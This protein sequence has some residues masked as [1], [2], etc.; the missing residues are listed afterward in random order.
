MKPLD[1]NLE[2]SNAPSIA[3]PGFDSLTTFQLTLVNDGRVVSSPKRKNPK[4]GSDLIGNV[5][6]CP[7]LEILRP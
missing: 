4:Y 5:L 3:R 7:D 1:K 6:A 2:E